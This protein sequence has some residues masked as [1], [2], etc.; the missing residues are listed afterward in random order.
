[1]KTY[2]AVPTP[3]RSHLLVLRIRSCPVLLGTKRLIRHP[4]TD[5]S[6]ETVHTSR[7][8]IGCLLHSLK[9][10]EMVWCGGVAK[11]IRFFFSSLEAEGREG[12]RVIVMLKF[13]LGGWLGWEWMLNT[14][15]SQT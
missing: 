1:M 7:A 13:E 15:S 5:R 3:P 9:V 10:G 2:S 8:G 11:G 12:G 14:E 4:E 6:L